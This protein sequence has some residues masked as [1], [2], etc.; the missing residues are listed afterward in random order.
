MKNIENTPDRLLND[1]RREAVTVVVD[2]LHPPGY[3]ATKEIA[4]PEPA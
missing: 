1:R 2:I 4:S 3:R